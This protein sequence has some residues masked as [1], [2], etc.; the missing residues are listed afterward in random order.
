[1]KIKD[2][3]EKYESE[4]LEL[5]NEFKIKLAKEI[6]DVALATY[7]QK[8]VYEQQ[9]Q[10][11]ENEIQRCHQIIVQQKV[12]I[13]QLQAENSRLRNTSSTSYQDISVI[14]SKY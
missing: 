10:S 14:G 7:N 4:K 1:M 2:L 13:Q 6:N 11:Q 3:I 5:R 8:K 9:L 12:E